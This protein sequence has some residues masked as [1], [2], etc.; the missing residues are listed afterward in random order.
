MLSYF[1]SFILSNHVKILCLEFLVIGCACYML[2]LGYFWSSWSPWKSSNGQL[3][4]R[5]IRRSLTMRWSLESFWVKKQLKIWNRELLNMWFT[6]F[7]TLFFM[8]QLFIW[9]LTCI[10]FV[11]LSEYS[12]CIKILRKDYFEETCTAFVSQPR[13]V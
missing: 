5:H 6:E 4:G 8:F 7:L 10:N 1:S 3:F 12:C 2:C 9:A 11:N 13:G